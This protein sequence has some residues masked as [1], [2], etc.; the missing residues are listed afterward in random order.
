MSP[1]TRTGLDPA[2]LDTLRGIVG[3]RYVLTS[4]GDVEVYSR[5]ATPLFR[6]TPDA[7]VLPATTE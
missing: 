1:A 5:D 4:D 2:A 3:E 6:G 7:V